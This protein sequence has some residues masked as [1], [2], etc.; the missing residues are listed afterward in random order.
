MWVGVGVPFYTHSTLMGANKP[1]TVFT[2]YYCNVNGM[3]DVCLLL[4]FIMCVRFVCECVCRCVCVHH[5]YVM[6]CGYMWIHV[7]SCACM[8][9]HVC[10]CCEQMCML[11]VCTWICHGLYVCVCVC[12][13]V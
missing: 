13:C 6:V 8:C 2:A 12:V 5:V 11:V 9:M 1:E 4:C 3:L 10:V 7:D